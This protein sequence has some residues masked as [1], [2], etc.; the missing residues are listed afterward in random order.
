MSQAVRSRIA[1]AVERHGEREVA[2]RAATLIRTGTE[3]PWFLV[4]VG[5]DAAGSGDPAQFERP[6]WAALARSWGARALQY[7]WDES[8]SAAVIAGLG[9]PAW[10]VRMNCARICALRELEAS[11]AL[12]PL[13]ADANWRVRDAAALA[14]GRTGEAEDLAAVLGLLDDGH[15]Q[16]RARAAQAVR[17]AQERLD[18][19]LD[20]DPRA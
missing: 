20:R 4:A 19:P 13:L 3:E 15:E 9:D 14:V 11:A 16:V 5:G 8:A 6:V 18:R 1:E 10:R 7:V 17:E 12:V 2:E